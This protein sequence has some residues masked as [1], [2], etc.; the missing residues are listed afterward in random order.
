MRRLKWLNES[1]VVPSGAG[2][3]NIIGAAAADALQYMDNNNNTNGG[4]HHFLDQ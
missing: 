3:P 2:Q 1:C 4:Q